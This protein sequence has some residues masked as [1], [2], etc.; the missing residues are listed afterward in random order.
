MLESERVAHFPPLKEIRRDIYNNF[1]NWQWDCN[2][3]INSDVP[4]VSENKRV[5]N[6][7]YQA[8]LFKDIPNDPK[9]QGASKYPMIGVFNHKG[10]TKYPTN[11]QYLQYAGFFFFLFFFVFCFLK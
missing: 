8:W 9:R 2:F 11:E 7:M 4:L 6:I 10:I 5:F 3:E 1:K